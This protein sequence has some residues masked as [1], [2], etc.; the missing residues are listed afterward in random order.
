MLKL[1]YPNATGG[2]GSGKPTA[3]KLATYKSQKRLT[4]FKPQLN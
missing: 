4:G 2:A 3:A 1:S